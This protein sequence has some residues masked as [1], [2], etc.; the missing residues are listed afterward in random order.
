MTT[1]KDDF[2]WGGDISANQAEGGWDEGGKSP[3]VTDY[4]LGGSRTTP[5]MVT[6]QMPDGSF[7]KAPAMAEIYQI[8]EGA[9]L[10]FM[11]GAYYPNHM[12]T[13]F[14]HHWK[15]DI[16]LFAEMGFTAFNLTLSWARILPNGVAG[17]VNQEGVEFYRQVFKELKAHGIEPIVHL[18]KYD[19]PAFYVEEMGGWANRRLIDEFVE[20]ARI[21]FREYKG[22]VRYWSTFNEINVLQFTITNGTA[23][24][25]SIKNNYLAL[26]NQLV[27]SA[28][29]VQLAHAQ[30]DQDLKVGCMVAGLFNYALTC[31]PKD[32]LATQKVMQDNFFY[33]ADT[34][35][36]GHY[37]SYAKR[38]WDE[39]DVSLDVSEEDAR[40]LAAGRVDFM[41]FS[42]YFTNV[43][44]THQEDLE[45]A[46]G[47]L[48]GGIKNPYLTV[49]DWGWAKD[50]DGLKYFL[51]E[52]YD[53]YQVPLFVVENGLGA[54]DTLEE[55]GSVHD[56]YRID[57][58]RDHIRSMKEAVNEGVDLI[59]YTTWGSIDIVSAGTGEIRKRYGFIYVDVDDEGHGTFKRY[60][61]DSFWW[62]KK[63]IAS[64]GEDLA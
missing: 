52:I 2:L 20:L 19:L 62:Y 12:A 10:A 15:E 57:Y 33:A 46:G 58:L 51:H 9:K 37:P 36:R 56:A 24:A 11:D 31:D 48:V 40:D 49:S 22:L 44:T 43:V 29:V 17:G 3:N 39:L 42:Y 13:D 1:F 61:K 23:D 32:E 63:C 41:E 26:H 16:A 50:P 18:Y 5:R 28:R 59:G 64:N 21:A 27:A 47:N 4:T 35:V 34:F 45:T 53:R 14:Y 8:P 30:Q 55:D 54:V 6:Y 38:L 60:R 25:S 7:G